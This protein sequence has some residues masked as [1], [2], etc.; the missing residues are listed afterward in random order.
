MPFWLLKTEP[1]TYSYGN[2]EKAGKDSWDGARNYKAQK[3]MRSMKPG[4]MVFIY[5]TGKE[6]SIIGVAGVISLPY[7]NPGSLDKNFVMVDVEARYRL[8]RPVTLKEI[9]A[10]PSL[11]DWELVTNSRLSVMPVSEMQWNWVYNKLVSSSFTL[12]HALV[13]GTLHFTH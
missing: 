8:A 4:D 9:K 11:S 7:P 10:E 6:R 3:Y 1:D 5:H 13:D 2:L 12:N